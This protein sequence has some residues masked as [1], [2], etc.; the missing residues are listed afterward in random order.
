MRASE[1]QRAGHKLGSEGEGWLKM[2]LNGDHTRDRTE[3][4]ASVKAFKA[5]LHGKLGFSV[6]HGTKPVPAPLHLLSVQRAN[7]TSIA[8]KPGEIRHPGQGAVHPFLTSGPHWPNTCQEKGVGEGSCI[9]L[10]KE[11]STRLP[12]PQQQVLRGN[13]LE[14]LVIQVEA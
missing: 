8:S 11:N 14:T 5:P 13:H 2:G 3:L 4:W 6:N 9:S 7:R 1:G 10:C 12:A